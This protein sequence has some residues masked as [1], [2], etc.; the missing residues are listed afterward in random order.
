[1]TLPRNVAK[2][3]SPLPQETLFDLVQE[4]I[5][6][7]KPQDVNGSSPTGKKLRSAIFRTPSFRGCVMSADDQ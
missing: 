5:D 4:E 3:K 1:M 6:E 7:G 2:K